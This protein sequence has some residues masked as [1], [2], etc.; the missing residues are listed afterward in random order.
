MIFISNLITNSL[1]SVLGWSPQI[2][3]DQFATDQDL[4]AYFI[5]TNAANILL[6]LSIDNDDNSKFGYSI[7]LPFQQTKLDEGQ[8][9]LSKITCNV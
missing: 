5:R 1:Q 6:A 8:Q 9:V 3:S 2:I 4:D 7:R